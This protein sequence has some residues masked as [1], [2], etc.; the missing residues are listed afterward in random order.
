[1]RLCIYVIMLC[2]LCACSA[3]KNVIGGQQGVTDQQKR[4]ASQTQLKVLVADFNAFKAA[5]LTMEQSPSEELKAYMKRMGTEIS[6]MAARAENLKKG[7]AGFLGSGRQ[8]ENLSSI[9]YISML[10]YHM[11]DQLV[12]L[13][14]PSSFDEE[15][16]AFFASAMKER[17][18]PLLRKSVEASKAFKEVCERVKMTS[19]CERFIESHKDDLPVQVAAAP[20]ETP[21]Q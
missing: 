14:P 10:Y 16:Q 19:Q 13:Q 1:M 7:F 15:T 2:A 17:A 4:A 6:K 9:A 12:H 3:N 11:H 5:P 18:E 8:F 20:V 21:K